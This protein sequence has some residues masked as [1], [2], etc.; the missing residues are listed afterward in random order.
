MQVWIY[1]QPGTGGDGFANLLE[2]CLSVQSLDQQLP[3]WRLHRYVDGEAKFWAPTVDHAGCFRYNQPF[4]YSNNQLFQ[5]YVDLVMTKQNMV[6]TSHDVLFVNIN[7]SDAQ[8]ILKQNQFRV[9]VTT[10]DPMKAMQTNLKKTLNSITNERLQQAAEW[11]LEL[12]RKIDHTAFDAV[13]YI[14]DVH[15]DQVAVNKFCQQIDWHL[16]PGY[17]SEYVDLIKGK[18][19]KPKIDHYVSEYNS[20]GVLEYTK[21]DFT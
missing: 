1:F 14:E 13:L 20:L 4:R 17:Y 19:K 10:Q 2:H 9:L 18:I 11:Y 5:C 21:L 12:Y 8:H 15:R 7:S 16:D 6:V 3:Q